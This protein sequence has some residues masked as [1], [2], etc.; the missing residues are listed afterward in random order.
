MNSYLKI[1]NALALL[2]W[3][4][5]LVYFIVEPDF[6]SSTI[7]ILS[8]AQGLAVLEI[9]HAYLDRVKSK[10]KVVAVQVFSRIFIVILIHQLKHLGSPHMT[11]DGRILIAVAWGFTEVVRYWH[12]LSTLRKKDNPG[13][14]WFRYSGFIILYPIG[15]TGE[16]LIAYQ[17]MYE[18][19]W[20]FDL[21]GIAVTVIVL[22]Y[23]VGFPVLFRHMI[24]QRRRK[25]RP[26]V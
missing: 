17:Y 26:K 9:L 18:R 10:W 4:A 21:A 11:I 12:Y 14:T 25:L 15:V 20:N 24:K 16:L 8:I 19:N 1:Y 3:L 6:N 23:S 2:A 7:L 13:L 22:S 5:F